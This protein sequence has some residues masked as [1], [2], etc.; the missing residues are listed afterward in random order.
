MPN[1]NSKSTQSDETEDDTTKLANFIAT[2][3]TPLPLD[4][5]QSQLTLLLNEVHQKR[6]Q[7]LV[8]FLARAIAKDMTTEQME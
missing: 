8:R 3:R 2:G 6:R 4:L 7:R 5:P 1:Q